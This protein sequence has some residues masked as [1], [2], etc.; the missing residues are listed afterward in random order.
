MI[1][2]GYGYYNW[3][4][5]YLDMVADSLPKQVSGIFDKFNRTSS[6]AGSIA[7]FRKIEL[8]DNTTLFDKM[9]DNMAEGMYGDVKENK[10]YILTMTKAIDR[11]FGE[12]DYDFIPQAWYLFQ[13]HLSHYIIPEGCET[14]QFQRVL[15][16]VSEQYGNDIDLSS[17]YRKTVAAMEAIESTE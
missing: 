13:N 9:V 17:V 3:N 2:G 15:K 12:Q 8:D 11:V 4:S 6:T 16:V 10:E 14:E 5:D 7:A 1:D